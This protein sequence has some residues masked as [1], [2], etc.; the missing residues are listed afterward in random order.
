MI[1]NRLHGR[2]DFRIPMLLACTSRKVGDLA[3]TI[4]RFET[5]FMQTVRR[6]S[7]YTTVEDMLVHDSVNKPQFIH[8]HRLFT[9]TP[10]YSIPVFGSWEMWLMHGNHVFVCILVVELFDVHWILR[11]R[12][13]ISSVLHRVTT[14]YVLWILCYPTNSLTYSPMSQLSMILFKV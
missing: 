6:N 14:L 12:V 8:Q 3:T 10:V 1:V 13:Y 9:T 11:G 2:A 4:I 5:S 7:V